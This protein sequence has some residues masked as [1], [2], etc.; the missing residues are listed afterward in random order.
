MIETVTTKKQIKKPL[1]KRIRFEIFKRDCFKCQYCGA[2][3]P[4]VVLHVDHIKPVSQGG[5]ND[6]TNLITSCAPCNLG[7]RDK[8]LDDNTVISK[9][10]AQMEELQERREQ[11]EM[12]ME[13]KEGLRDLN[14]DVLDRLCEYWHEHAPGYTVNDNGQKHIKKWLRKFSLDEITSAMDVAAESYLKFN[15][16]GTVTSESWEE[17]FA[18]IPGICRVERDSKE[19]P[20]LKTLYY[21]RG[22]ARNRC[23]YFN[24]QEALDWL[25]A[26][27]SWDVE[28]DE[29]RQ[30]ACNCRSWTYFRN[31]IID[32]IDNKKELQGYKEE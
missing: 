9:A 12:M 8:K 2:T 24:N 17:A 27:R 32:A 31:K 28:M 7:K 30:I 18:K 6:L 25:K 16:E 1:S 13:W 3:A 5:S 21:I 29:L 15:E 4:E 10:R 23:N 26:A 20:D 19:N 11:L 14:Q 22:I